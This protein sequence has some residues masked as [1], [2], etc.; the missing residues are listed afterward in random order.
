MKISAI[1]S[2]RAHR[3]HFCDVPRIHGKKRSHP[4]IMEEV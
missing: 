3:L 1:L 4:C 2:M